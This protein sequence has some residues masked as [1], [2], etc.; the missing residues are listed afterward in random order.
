VDRS[1]LVVRYLAN[2]HAHF[3][4]IGA[5]SALAQA[6]GAP[7][8]VHEDDLPLLEGGGLLPRGVPREMVPQGLPDWVT[9]G[10]ALPQA[11]QLLHDGDEIAV[12]SARLRVIHTPGHTP[13]SICL[14]CQAE[15]L[16]FSGD[17]LFHLG[18]G[19]AD[20]PGGHGRTLLQSIK[21]RL[22]TLP[23]NTTVYPGH[24][25]STTIGLE[26]RRNPFVRPV[27]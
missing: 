6:T 8:L 9:E 24:G 14:Y 25:P 12:G 3:D 26:K 7:V 10:V 2:T 22:Y 23:D 27:S 1:R 18:V 4:H 17:T 19:R 21:E 11:P 16:L 13:G 20:M 15:A 5:L